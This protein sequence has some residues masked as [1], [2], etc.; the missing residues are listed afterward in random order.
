MGGLRLPVYM[1]EST[2]LQGLFSGI[3]KIRLIYGL[4]DKENVLMAFDGA[5]GVIFRNL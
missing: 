4:S 5:L 2:E 3:Q 1:G